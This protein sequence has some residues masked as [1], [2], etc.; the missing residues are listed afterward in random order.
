MKKFLE[1]K[2]KCLTPI[3]LNGII[4]VKNNSWV[5]SLFG[6]EHSAFTLNHFPEVGSQVCFHC[7][8]WRLII[9]CS[10]N[11]FSDSVRVDKILWKQ[12]PSFPN[13]KI[14]ARANKTNHH[15]SAREGREWIVSRWWKWAWD[16]RDNRT[17]ASH[18]VSETLY[19][20]QLYKSAFHI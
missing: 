5:S 2:I 7:R 13:W 16:R 3:C 14:L 11:N 20:T 8:T 18:L 1:K 15:K 6:W 10:G 9:S 19:I 12:R 17:G 4:M